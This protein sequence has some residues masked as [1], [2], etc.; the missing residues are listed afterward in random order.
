MQS[1]WNA[2][3]QGCGTVSGSLAQCRLTPCRL[4][5]RELAPRELAQRGQLKKE[6]RS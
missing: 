2:P 1:G 6:E 5:P 4:M 3:P